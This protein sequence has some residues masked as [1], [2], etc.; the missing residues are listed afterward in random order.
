[1]SYI[2]SV[3]DGVNCFTCSTGNGSLSTEGY[4]LMTPVQ[5]RHNNV[6]HPMIMVAGEENATASFWYLKTDSTNPLFVDSGNF[7]GQVL[8]L[9]CLNYLLPLKL[10]V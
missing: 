5:R 6:H 8:R 2:R 4:R 7:F 1:M 10:Y 3:L 9:V